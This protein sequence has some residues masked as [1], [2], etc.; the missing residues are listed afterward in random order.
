LWYRS[1]FGSGLLLLFQ[2]FC[3]CTW[4]VGLTFIS[5]WRILLEFLYG[6]FHNILPIHENRM[7]FHLVISSLISFCSYL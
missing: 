6:H 2:F 5:R 4:T 3:A 7:S 1:S